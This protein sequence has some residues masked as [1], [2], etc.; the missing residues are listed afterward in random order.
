M[1]WTNTFLPTLREVPSA[2][3]GQPE[4]WLLRAGLLGFSNAGYAW[5]PLGIRMLRK[6]QQQVRCRLLEAGA[7]EIGLSSLVPVSLWERSHLRDW[8]EPSGLRVDL[9]Q[10]ERKTRY[11]LAGWQEPVLADMLAGWLASYRN[12]PLLL[13]QFTPGVSSPPSS[14]VLLPETALRPGV[15][16]YGFHPTPES[17]HCSYQQLLQ[18]TERLLDWLEL[19]Y[20]VAQ[21][22][23][24]GGEE[25]HRVIVRLWLAHQGDAGSSPLPGSSERLASSAEKP[26]LSE[27]EGS[28][29]NEVPPES[30]RWA[31]FLEEVAFC[32]QCGYTAIADSTRIGGRPTRPVPAECL[33]AHPPA[34]ATHHPPLP[35]EEPFRCVPT[36]GASTIAEVTAFLGRP[37]H[38]FLKTLIYLAD[39]Q[40]VAVLIR[41]DHQASASKICRAFG[42]GR[43]E[44]A[45]PATIEKVTGA[46]VGFSGPVGMKERIA[47]WADW[48]VQD[49]QNVVVG[50]NRA[51]AHL[52]GVCIGRDF[53]PDFFADLRRATP[54]DPCPQCP[55]R[56]QIARGLSVADSACLA[57]EISHQLALRFHDTQEKLQPVRIHRFQLDL[58]RVLWAIAAVHHDAQGLVWP[59]WFAPYDLLLVCLA[60]QEQAIRKATEE[61][62]EACQKAGLE[63]LLDDRELRPGVKFFDAD[64]LGIPWRAVLGP[65]NY[66]QGQ[67][68]LKHRRTGQ[69]QIIPL[70]QAASTIIEKIQ[71]TLN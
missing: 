37:A 49:A 10:A 18:Q 64:L 25:A 32:E 69:K 16:V 71:T 22:H 2:L 17:L 70:P 35:D 54:G 34:Q 20:W 43:L 46:P 21:S 39:G 58:A 5:W 30:S 55:A 68:E 41:G 24:P 45:D 1:R 36:P 66:Q 47:I 28:P 31:S 50:A 60:P 33:L 53:H 61:L 3:R 12:L 6:L 67:L 7:Q 13:F 26:E 57:P 56:L 59:K 15:Q 44:M 62:Y 19:P 27:Q 42:I 63:V 65:K 29:G 9:A 14:S 8:L 48:D 23:H 4:E 40:P 51:D 52:V 38:Q 11:L